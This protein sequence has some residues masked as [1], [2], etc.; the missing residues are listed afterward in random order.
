MGTKRTASSFREQVMGRSLG[1]VAIAGLVLLA[2]A[3]SGSSKAQDGADVCSPSTRRCEGQDVVRC[4]GDGSAE[5]VVETC[6]APQACS[7]GQ[8]KSALC[9]ANTKFCKDGAVW[10]CDSTGGGSTLAQMCGSGK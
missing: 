3:C 6:E 1:A 9:V 10:K 4:N 8:C 2:A 5:A 7:D